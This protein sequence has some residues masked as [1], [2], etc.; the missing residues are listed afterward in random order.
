[1]RLG[2]EVAT[3]QGV[4]REGVD[5]V[6]QTAGK[7]TELLLL[8]LPLNEK[9]FKMLVWNWAQWFALIVPA[10]WRVEAGG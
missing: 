5:Q 10:S 2:D 6:A 7:Q 4:I 8:L 1:M 3:L 9:T